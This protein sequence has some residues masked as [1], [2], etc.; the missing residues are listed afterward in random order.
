[1]ELDESIAVFGSMELFEDFDDEQLRLLAFVSET[2]DLE[3]G[4]VIYAAGDAPNGAYLLVSGSLEARHDER[5]SAIYRISP[6]ALVG[7]M[8]LVLT[9]PRATT[10]VVRTRARVLFVPR[11]PFMKLLR[12]DP[13]LAASVADKIRAELARYLGA[14]EQLK[15]RFT[16]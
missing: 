6:P 14:I 5:P 8:G 3:P 11:E 7:E 4:D 10:I 12:S 1:M 15:S 13:D 9:R 2:R 16:H